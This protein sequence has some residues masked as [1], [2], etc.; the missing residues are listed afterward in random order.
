[1]SFTS[2]ALKWSLISWRTVLNTS[3][4]IFFPC[5]FPI[6]FWLGFSDIWYGSLCNNLLHFVYLCF[7]ACVDCRVMNDM[8]RLKQEWRQENWHELD[9]MME[10]DECPVNGKLLA[11]TT[12]H[13]C[14]YFKNVFIL[15]LNLGRII[16]INAQKLSWMRGTC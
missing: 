8:I 5:L 7:W 12:D 14:N 16:S 9:I 6:W 15:S 4:K 1:M 13:F 2:R 11:P 3:M 10:I